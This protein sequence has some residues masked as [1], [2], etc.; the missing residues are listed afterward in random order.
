MSNVTI[1]KVTEKGVKDVTRKFVFPKV[2]FITD[3]KNFETPY[4]AL[5]EKSNCIYSLVSYFMGWTKLPP[6]Q[7]AIKWNTYNDKVRAV[8][9]EMRNNS[10]CGIRKT[11]LPGKH[12][13]SDII[14]F[15]IMS[16]NKC[17]ICSFDFFTFSEIC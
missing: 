17:F 9:V 3:R 6:D 11:L 16:C 14:Y 10:I 15:V 13:V 8:I 12:C 5:R 4:E 1:N 2:K 7:C